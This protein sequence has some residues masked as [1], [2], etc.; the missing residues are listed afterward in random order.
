MTFWMRLEG[1][2]IFARRFD[3]SQLY[4]IYQYPIT[5]KIID[6]SVIF[7]LV[8]IVGMVESLAITQGI[9]IKLTPHGELIS[10]IHFSY[11]DDLNINIIQAI[12]INVQDSIIFGRTKDGYN[13]DSFKRIN[14]RIKL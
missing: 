5:L 11:F 1:D 12:P 9:I 6:D 13:S 4:V 7:S 2:I 3:V 10:I 8:L 14:N